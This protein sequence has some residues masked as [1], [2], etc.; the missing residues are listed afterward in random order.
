MNIKKYFTWALTGALG[1]ASTAFFTACSSDDP[2]NGN[3][4]N[5]PDGGAEEAGVYV[6]P[7]TV[8]DGKYLLTATSLDEGTVSAK[9]NGVEAVSALYWVYQNNELFALVYNQ[10]NAGTGESYYLNNDGKIEKHFTYTMSRFTTYGVWGDDL[11]TVSTGNSTEKDEDGNLAQA[12]LF[13]KVNTTDA[14]KKEHSV[15]SENLLGNGEKVTMAGIVNLNGKLYTSIVPMGM[16]KYGIKKWPDKVT[17]QNLIAK[18]DGGSNSASYKA[19]EIPSTQ[20]PDKAF[21]AIYENEDFT[22]PSKII[23]TDKIGYACGRFKSQYYQTIWAADNGDLYVFSPGY[24]R[25][26]KSSAD[27]KK[28]TGKLESGVVRIKAGTDEF[29]KDYYFNF[30]QIGTKHPVYRCWHITGDYF[31]LQ[32]Y[33]K[34]IDDVI[35]NG[36]KADVSELVVFK[37]E[38]GDITPVT[39]LPAD[40]TLTGEPYKE[41]GFAYMAVTVTSGA[42]PAFY[43]I[44]PTTGKAVKGLTVEAESIST[45]GKMNKKSY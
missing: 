34:G 30:E 10:G 38:T 29:D 37:G 35:A 17:D 25:T 12:F 16:S 40:A 27:L 5:T 15:I 33:K 7:A 11:I 42:Y 28:V 31:L 20:H 23:S 18:A 21:V 9:N 36:T 32:L 6:I 41:N 26:T 39:G 43:K 1:L 45:A 14:S 22:K 13:N 8:G 44:D 3:G 19:G 2:E 4:G 24:A